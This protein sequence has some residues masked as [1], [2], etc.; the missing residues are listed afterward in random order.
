MAEAELVAL[1]LNVKE[2]R[3][4]RLNLDELGNTNP[5]GPI[6]CDNDT[7]AGIKNGTAKKKRSRSTEMIDFYVCDQVKQCVVNI[8]WHTGQE[9]LGDYTSKNHDTL[10]HK[11]VC[12]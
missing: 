9:N 7:A 6:H 11:L 2:A 3:I 4:M 10:H 5:T 8:L 1:F 12:T